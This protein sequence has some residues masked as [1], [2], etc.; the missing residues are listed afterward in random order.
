M[1]SRNYFYLVLIIFIFLISF[2]TVSVL[3]PTNSIQINYG[4][5]I[6]FLGILP[7][8]INFFDKKES[9]LIPLMPLSGLFYLIA[10]GAPTFSSKI[11]YYNGVDE[12]MVIE[13]LQITVLGLI[14][15]YIGFYL[16][17]NF[18]SKGTSF[19]FLNDVPIGTEMIVKESN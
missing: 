17:R 16:F 13:A 18:Y 12:N 10:F 8:L 1:V 11:Y 14:F 5:I 9:N 2:I 15:L 7:I 19:I 3:E 6:I 4:L